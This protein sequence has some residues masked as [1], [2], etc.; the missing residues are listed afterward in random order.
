MK[1]INNRQIV[2][3]CCNEDESSSTVVKKKYVHKL[4]IDNF[5][6]SCALKFNILKKNKKILSFKLILFTNSWNN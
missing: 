5:I 2:Q 6:T 4:C 3:G 1:E